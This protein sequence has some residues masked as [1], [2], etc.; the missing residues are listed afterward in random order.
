MINDALIEKRHRLEDYFLELGDAAIAFSGGVDSTYLLAVGAKVLKKKVIALTIKTPYVPDRELEESVSFCSEMD[1]RHIIIHENIPESIRNN[2][3]N[4]CYICKRHI[5]SV[6]YK[7]TKNEGFSHLLEGSNLDD[8]KDY[9]PGMRALKELGIKSPLLECGIDKQ[10]VRLL[11]AHLSLPTADKPSYACLLTRFPYGCQVSEKDLNKLE[12]AENF[13]TS[14]G[15]AGCRLRLHNDLVRIEI[16]TDRI[17][18][19]IA[20]GSAQKVSKFLKNLGF[21]YI[22]LD[23]EGYRTGSFNV[24]IKSNDNE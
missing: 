2:P 5:F 3:E 21:T 20:D 13:V 16:Q 7:I 9:R 10:E 15:F 23:L 4:R 11:S 12:M 24:N 6:L 19:F 8:T 17:K 1:I 18:D 22:T 14:L